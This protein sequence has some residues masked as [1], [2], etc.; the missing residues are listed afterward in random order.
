MDMD[1]ELIKVGTGL[2]TQIV[3]SSAQTISNR[4]DVLK[5]SKKDK[6]VIN[7]LQEIINDL[8]D[9]R[10]Q[11]VQLTQSYEEKLIAQRISEKDIDYITD[12]IVPLLEGVLESSEDKN[13]EKNKE[14]LKAIE[15]ILSKETFNILQLL[16]F[17]FK[18]AIGEPL[19]ELLR[20]SISSQIPI[21]QEAHVK[22]QTLTE[23]KELE[24]LK[25]VNDEE[26]YE[27]Y[28]KLINI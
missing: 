8:I 4:I 13:A 5:T 12:K 17:N 23:E 11:L 20:K 25:M 16:G 7:E 28:Q 27:R 10:S 3:K 2:A 15:G 19:T 21:S 6:E 18:I 24:F 9:E 22:Y 1:P 14:N 26:A